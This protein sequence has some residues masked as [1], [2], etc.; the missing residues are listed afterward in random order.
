MTL[1]TRA[2]RRCWSTEYVNRGNARCASWHTRGRHVACG[3]GLAWYRGSA[4]PAC[5]RDVSSRGRLRRLP[6][7]RWRPCCHVGASRTFHMPRARQPSPDRRRRE[8]GGALR[9][10]RTRPPRVHD[11]ASGGAGDP[12]ASTA[13][14]TGRVQRRSFQPHTW[15]KACDARGACAR[16]ARGARAP[17]VARSSVF[18][19]RSGSRLYAGL[20]R[21]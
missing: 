17:F 16:G 2:G 14:R 19:V 8:G 9:Y 6:R 3:C 15:R 5:V 7:P 11:R 21:R 1:G 13:S 18:R 12:R 10:R 20:K 4:G